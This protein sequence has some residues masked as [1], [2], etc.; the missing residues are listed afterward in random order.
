MRRFI[1]IC[2]SLY[3]G[4][5]LFEKFLEV[6]KDAFIYWK[7]SVVCAF[8]FFIGTWVYLFFTFATLSAISQCDKK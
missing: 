6:N 1:D 5:V 4:N 8:L 2:I 3:A 7:D